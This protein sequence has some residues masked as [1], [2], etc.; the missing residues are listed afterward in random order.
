MGEMNVEIKSLSTTGGFK[1]GMIGGKIHSSRQSLKKKNVLV[2]R[3]NASDL[4][5]NVNSESKDEHGN[6]FSFNKNGIKIKNPGS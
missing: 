6:F 5:S 2:V 3:K 1:K 4:E